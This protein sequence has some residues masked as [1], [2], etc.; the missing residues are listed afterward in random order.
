MDEVVKEGPRK[1]W[2]I[3]GFILLLLIGSGGGYLFWKQN[4]MHNK[5]LEEILTMRLEGLKEDT[6]E[7]YLQYQVEGSR[8]TISNDSLIAQ[9]ETSKAQIQRLMEELKTVKATNKQR[10]NELTKE[11]ETLRKV[12]KHYVNQID[13]LNNENIKLKDDN[14]QIT[15]R[16]NAA[17]SSVTQLKRQNADL[18]EQLQ[19]AQ[20][21]D[22]VNIQTTLL[23]AKGKAAKTIKQ[24]SQLQLTFVINKNENA[25]AGEQVI[26]ICLIKPDDNILTKPNAGTFPYE[27]KSIPY[28]MKRTIEF[29]GQEQPVVM[30]WDIE[31]YLSPG[32]YRADIF[33]DGYLMGR[34]SFRLE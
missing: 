4:D 13:S 8:Y 3:M 30:Y 25:R 10:I 11:I 34:K 12:L 24:A 18:S 27:N 22:A 21:L 28:S 16:Y 5:E 7:L 14:Q 19:R 1:I 17:S 9:L 15:R 2:W 29:D 32:A 6:E 23:N 33:T 31:E 20:Q 26:F